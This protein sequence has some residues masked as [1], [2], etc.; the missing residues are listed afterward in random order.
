MIKDNYNKISKILNKSEKRYYKIY[1]FSFIIISILETLSVGLIPAYFTI[2]LDTNLLLE[3]LKFNEY[4]YKSIKLL[5]DSGNIVIYF[6]FVILVFFSIK[7]IY[8]VVFH[9]FEAK[10]FNTIKIRLSTSMVSIYLKKNYL[11]HSI[12]NPLILGRNITSEV[13]STIAYLKSF[14]IIIKEIIQISLILLLLLFANIK[15]TLLIIFLSVILTFIYLKTFS[16]KLVQKSKISFLERGEKSKIINQILNSIIEVKIYN[17]SKFFIDKFTK[18]IIREFSSNM[19]L[20]IVNKLPKVFIEFFIVLL[21]SGS[22][23]FALYLNLDLI[24]LIPIVALYFFSALRVYPSLNAILLNRLSL[25]QTQISI[26][27]IYNEILEKNKNVDDYDD[28]TQNINF[29]NSIELKDVSFKYKNR[30]MQLK[31]IDL[32]I[33][34]NE[35]VGI[36]GETGSGK[37]T[38]IK[39]IMGLIEPDSGVI[40]I[41]N[42][43]LS[44]I[45][46]SWQKKIGYVPQNFSILDDTI[47]ENIIFGGNNEDNHGEKIKKVIKDAYLEDFINTLPEKTRT[48]VGPDGKQISGGQAQRLAIARALHQ[49]PKLIIFDEATN[50]LDEKTEEEII[51]NIYELSKNKT[52][53]IITHK[54]SLLRNCD[55]VFKIE[56]G[57]LTRI[58]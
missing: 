5:L 30:K 8:S 43:N 14:A 33:N 23:F 28:N 16:S 24:S 48:I 56:D 50:S 3:Q 2:I 6:T 38:L 25:I 58:N 12:N 29:E 53:I 51:K 11:F 39:I 10:Y 57:K 34:K 46:K 15:I 42:T 1:F 21:V 26:N 20:E 17:K 52:I 27:H 49:D 55:K 13:N 40:N 19:L 32:K 9:Y 54:K 36:V 4:L 45:K 7:F 18:S 22:I 41:D 35:I 44:S 31:N 47:H 37:S